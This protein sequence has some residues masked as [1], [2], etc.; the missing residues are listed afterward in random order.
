MDLGVLIFTDF[1]GTLNVFMTG[2]D[3]NGPSGEGSLGVKII[4]RY[5]FTLNL[6][7]KVPHLVPNQSFNLPMDFMLANG[8]WDLMKKNQITANFYTDPDQD[9]Q[10]LEKGDI[11]ISINNIDSKTLMNRAGKLKKL[12][13]LD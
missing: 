4:S 7:D 13:G 10:L 11:I 8:T 9:K 12:Q 5:N 3:K 1:P 6:A 2:D